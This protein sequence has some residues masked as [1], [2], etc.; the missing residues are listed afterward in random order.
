MQQHGTRH[1]TRSGQ[2]RWSAT[3]FKKRALMST[4]QGAG[5]RVEVNVVVHNGESMHGRRRDVAEL[6]QMLSSRASRS[7]VDASKSTFEQLPRRTVG[8]EPSRQH[9]VGERLDR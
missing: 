3:R 2:P 8:S 7:R 5:D 9:F 4:K 6:P 1:T